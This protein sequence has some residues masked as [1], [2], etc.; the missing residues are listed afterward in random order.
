MKCI[1]IILLFSCFFAH[2]LPG[3]YFELGGILGGSNYL[4]DLTPSKFWTSVGETDIYSGIFGRYHLNDRVALRSGLNFGLIGANDAKAIN[5]DRARFMRNLSF[6]SNLIE[7]E[8]GVQISLFRYQP[9]NLQKRLTPYGFLGLGIF[10]HNPQGFYQEKWHDLQTLGTEG[11]G[12][13]N[14]PDK[15]SLTQISIPIGFGI[16][17]AL[18]SN[19]NIGFEYGM[20][21]TFTDYLDDTSGFY[22]DLDELARKKGELA[23]K[24]SWRTNEILPDA[25]PPLPGAQRGDPKDLDWYIFTGLYLSYNFIYDFGYSKMKKKA[26]NKCPKFGK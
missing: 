3:Q 15:Y 18:S 12:L 21:I 2:N 20:R 9:R 25:S 10:K 24:L 4:G 17:Y 1:G 26:K 16:K 19:I 22:P 13:D 6:R 23:R 8:L 7:L 11:Q 5:L 14:Y